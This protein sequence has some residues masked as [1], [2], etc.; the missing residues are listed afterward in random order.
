MSG[1][2]IEHKEKQLETK[3]RNFAELK[4]KVVNQAHPLDG[5]NLFQLINFS[6]LSPIY[7]FVGAGLEFKPKDNFRSPKALKCQSNLKRG[8][9][10]IH[11]EGRLAWR[12][13]KEFK[14]ELITNFLISQASA[15]L[16]MFQI[17]TTTRLVNTLQNYL[18]SS[19]QLQPQLLDG[20]SLSPNVS[21]YTLNLVLF[22]LAAVILTETLLSVFKVACDLH[23]SLFQKQ[24]SITFGTLFF[25]EQIESKFN[26]IHAKRF[27]IQ[28]EKTAG[29]LIGAISKLINA[30]QS[31]S[32]SLFVLIYGFR[33]FGA[34]F[35]IMI[36]GISI[37]SFVEYTVKKNDAR[38]EQDIQDTKVEL[39]S[40]TRSVLENLQY[41]KTSSLEDYY[42]RKAEVL[43]SR[44][45][46]NVTGSQMKLVST[47]FLF[48]LLS[49]STKLAFMWSFVADGGMLTA[50]FIKII[51]EVDNYVIGYR[52][53]SKL[54]GGF[55]AEIALK[56]HLLDGACEEIRAFQKLKKRVKDLEDDSQKIE[57]GTCLLKGS[58]YWNLKDGSQPQKDD[59]S[60]A[61]VDS[62]GRK[63]G[64]ELKNIDFR[65]EKGSLTMII[66]KIGSGKSSLI[67][68]LVGEMNIDYKNPSKVVRRLN[69][70]VAYLGQKPWV[71]NATVKE[72]ILLGKE[73]KEDYFKKCIKYSA[74]EDDLTHWAKGVDHLVGDGGV[75]I[76]GGQKARLALARCLYQDAD[77]YLIDDVTSALDVH[78]GGMVFNKTIKEFL[79]EKT[80]VMTT[81]NIQQVKESDFIYY[82]EEG[83]VKIKGQ[84][85]DVQDSELYRALV[86]QKEAI[87]LISKPEEAKEAEKKAE[88]Q[89]ETSEKKEANKEKTK[90]EDRGQPQ[91][92]DKN[93]GKELAATL[94]T[95]DQDLSNN[96]I[97]S[98]TYQRLIQ[99]VFCKEYMIL[100]FMAAIEG[101]AST[102][103]EITLNKWANNFKK[104][105]T[106]RTFA[107]YCSL[108]L[109]N[110]FLGSAM[111]LVRRFANIL[112]ENRIASERVYKVLHSNLET[113][114]DRESQK[115]LSPTR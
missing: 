93:K 9:T 96:K 114:V 64:F 28:S 56:E 88:I 2:D 26:D 112:K 40:L 84:F 22:Q 42:Y 30:I 59:F 34:K 89:Q 14:V 69:G 50:G 55:W 77:I 103:T 38:V 27:R 5:K 33:M 70:S 21:E 71:M 85:K 10:L 94:L 65:A 39:E 91:S 8:R 68:A 16:T 98:K 110:Q 58:Y 17:T 20:S 23:T 63:I 3:E 25:E 15:V 78:V 1:K 81:H 100:F 53:F 36:V 66:G 35:S 11:G 108:D 46:N 75:T 106:L 80:V 49:L 83:E 4:Q 82:M 37:S 97:T 92:K 32:R 13:A 47:D 43:R 104:A 109:F 105:N 95:A 6:Y 52:G 86:H 18:S 51:S 62:S 113:F 115:A 7:R 45:S 74:L 54:F 107:I 102:R 31:F 24:V 87:T 44:I 67:Q 29:E 41:V 60:G 101:Y 99:E 19:S 73:Y 79:K 12:I 57:V 72:N 61:G 111:D 48:K 90:N 76:S